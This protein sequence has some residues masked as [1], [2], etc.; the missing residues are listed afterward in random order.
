[1]PNPNSLS[2]EVQASSPRSIRSG[3][4]SSLRRA[5]YQ[6]TRVAQSVPILA[7][8]ARVLLLLI[9]TVP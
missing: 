1:M 9:G 2:S 4:V 8:I 6:L 7:G 5:A 3:V